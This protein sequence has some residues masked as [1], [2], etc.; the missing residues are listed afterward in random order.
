MNFQR[1]TKQGCHVFTPLKAFLIKDNTVKLRQRLKR[2]PFLLLF[3]AVLPL[4]RIKVLNKELP[5]VGDTS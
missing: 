1:A 3:I 2:V 4:T 5:R